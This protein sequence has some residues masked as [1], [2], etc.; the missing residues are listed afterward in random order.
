MRISSG[1]QQKGILM[2]EKRSMGGQ[3]KCSLVSAKINREPGVEMTLLK[4]IFAYNRVAAGE[5]ESKG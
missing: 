5:Y 2:Y 3:R 1:I 4:I